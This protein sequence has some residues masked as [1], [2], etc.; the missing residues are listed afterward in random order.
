MG[1]FKKRLKER[2]EMVRKQNA[3]SVI[4][5]ARQFSKNNRQIEEQ[6]KSVIVR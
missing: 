6:I 2:A 1:D 4:R 5:Y 3:S